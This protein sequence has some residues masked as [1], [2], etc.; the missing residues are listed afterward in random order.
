M[1]KEF[2]LMLIIVICAIL[3]IVT[4]IVVNLLYTN[5]IVIDELIVNTIS[6]EDVMFLVFFAWIVVGIIIGVFKD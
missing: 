1:R 6:I 3:G 4:A 2:E 5:G